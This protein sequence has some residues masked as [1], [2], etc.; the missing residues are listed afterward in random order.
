MTA[1]AWRW[2][3]STVWL[4]SSIAAYG[5]HWSFQSYGPDAG[6]T[7]PTVL[8]LH[9]D[10]KGFL[11]VSTEGGLFR[12]DG[13]RFRVFEARQTGKG[14]DITSLH[15]SPDGQLWA[16]S[17]AGLFR[18]SSDH[19]IAVP[20]T[21]NL[22][23]EGAQAIASDDKELYLASNSG[24]WSLPFAAAASPRQIT[25]KP[26]ASIFVGRNRTIWFGC[27]SSLCT[28]EDGRAEERKVGKGL[29][30]GPWNSIVE[31]SNGNLWI[32]SP[33]RVLVRESG[34]GAFRQVVTL[35][36]SHRALLVPGRHGEV[37]A[38][39]SGG[40]AICTQ[41]GCRNYGVESGLQHSEP[42][43]VEEDREGSLWIGYSGHGL[44]RWIGREEWQS[45]AEPEGL[46]DS[47]IWR[48]VRD[49]AGDLWIGT[50]RGLF[51]GSEQDG[52][53]HFRRSEVM[54]DWTVY[55]LLADPDGSL[56][57]GTF[58][59]GFKG[60]VHYFPQ[61]GRKVVYPP[62]RPMAQFSVTGLSRDSTGT[63]WVA[64]QK[65]VLRLNLR[66]Q[67]LETVDLPVSGSSIHSIVHGAGA[68]Y[69]SGQKGLYI[70]RGK[71]HRL[72][73]AKDGLKD[74][75]VQSVLIGPS[76]E[77]WIAYFPSVGI[78]RLDWTGE[79]FQLRHFST[80][81]G[82][83]SNLVYSQFFD[84]RGRH[85]IG[86]DV[87]AAVLEGNGWVQHDTSD[88]LV[89]NDCNAQS[90]L[91]EPD[92][93]VWIGTSA[94]M[95]RFFPA[96]RTLRPV[97]S[98]LITALMRNDV[99]TSGNVFDSKTRTV[100]LR[101][102]M[103]SYK[104]QTPLFRYRLGFTNPWIET[105]ANEVHFAELPQGNYHFEVQ[106]DI[107]RGVWSHPAMRDF[108]IRP[109]WFRSLP[110]LLTA[111]STLGGLIWFGWRRRERNQQKLRA[112]LERAVEERTRSL[113]AA[114]A[115]AEQES[116]FKGEFLSN[117]S[118]EMRTPLNGVLG[119]TKLAL[120]LSNQPEVVGHLSTV[121][122]S[123]KILL[124][125]I[126]DVLDLAKIE[127]G[128]LEIV[129]V[130]FAP[131]PL[132]E[133]ACSMLGSEARSK[134]LH[135]ELSIDATVPEWVRADDSRLRQVLV[136]LIGNAIKFT[137]SGGVTV[138]LRHDGEH[139]Q[140]GV[141]D[142][143]IGIAQE[144]QAIVFDVFR[145]ADS[146]ISR[147][148]GGSGLGLAI[149]RKL[150]ESMGGTICLQSEPGC[151]ST[152]SFAVAAPVAAAPAVQT[153]VSM[154]APSRPLRILVAEDNK[155]NQHL[156][157]ALLRKRGHNPAIANNG[158]EAIAACANEAFDLVL[159][160]IQMPEMDGIQAVRR[161]R[162]VEASSGTRIPVVAV[163]ARAMLGDRDEIMAAGMDAYIEKPIRTEQLEEVLSRFSRPYSRPAAE[164]D[165]LENANLN[166]ELAMK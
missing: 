42:L 113:A 137:A 105:R 90:Y 106:G 110:F 134:G 46:T 84:A 140:C 139:L 21:A 144:Q 97:P 143:G 93:A 20:G 27:G 120:E 121:Q 119:L 117:M 14:A 89:W 159:M 147:R 66:S 101:F 73:T 61:T 36:S 163:T 146:S 148:H 123:A 152:F 164:H 82:I 83:P 28:L 165:P 69:V 127:A 65:Q 114:M 85:W 10:R 74:T 131:R 70:E 116:R 58:Q 122:F 39:H 5:Q 3:R 98:G 79:Q 18:W 77:A 75:A 71:M 150:V 76:G 30:S 41:Q 128:M 25:T 109:P 2:I 67:S 6:L 33:E 145:Q 59:S 60:L 160:D 115:R 136:N 125:L 124:S 13:D 126:N 135:V 26:V 102:T 103:L 111:A 78:S 86:T 141:T 24:L 64:A 142:T 87:G 48:I 8:A 44:V 4:F 23:L 118:H 108:V 15:T 29:P 34:D 104:R 31:D 157:M 17:A 112:E 133:E 7:N 63:I 37:M 38:P 12:Y 54:R 138:A 166:V 81:D 96:A 158:R 99:A 47:Q 56:W 16:G 155:V 154:D 156:L 107:G 151:G 9:Q 91:A 162:E 72:L 40:L 100:A 35:N 51:R 22:E 130:A 43:T 92:G 80:V 94:G 19:F 149:S 50:N 129:P 88:G 153:E 52:R 95:S 62:D 68:T 49:P 55:G 57:V 32:R 11:W 1:S 45:F 132:F 53:W 161:L